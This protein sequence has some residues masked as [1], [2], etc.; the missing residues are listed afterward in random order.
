[1]TATGSPAPAGEG[2]GL[3]PCLGP[4]LKQ[5][6]RGLGLSLRAVEQATERTVTNGY[7]SQIES[8]LVARPSPNVLYRLAQAYGID[9]SDLMVRAGHHVPSDQPS[10][11]RGAVAGLPL[12]ALEDLTEQ[13]RGQLLEYIAFLR[14]R[15]AAGGGA[16]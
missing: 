4:H 11:A 5:V 15:R 6:R 14:S 7:L 3:S 2:E 8:G 16:S 13:E 12:R 10:E 1:M 9:F